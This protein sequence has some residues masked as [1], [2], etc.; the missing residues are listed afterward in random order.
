MV[1][2][3]AVVARHDFLDDLQVLAVSRHRRPL[4]QDGLGLR[5]KALVML[6]PRIWQFPRL[7]HD[8]VRSGG[9]HFLHEAPDGGLAVHD[10]DAIVHVGQ[11]DQRD[12]VARGVRPR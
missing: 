5:D 1:Q 6:P 2:E 11:R 7:I 9:Q 12:L 8:V 10:G 4:L 3:Q